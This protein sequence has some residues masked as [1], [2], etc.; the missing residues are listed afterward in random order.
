MCRARL[1]ETLY[2]AVVE[3]YANTNKESTPCSIDGVHDCCFGAAKLILCSTCCIDVGA[4]TVDKQLRFC[5]FFLLFTPDTRA[6]DRWFRSC[7][8]PSSLAF[9]LS[10]SFL[11]SLSLSLSR[12]LLRVLSPFPTHLF[13]LLSHTPASFALF[14]SHPLFCFFLGWVCLFEMNLKACWAW[15]NWQ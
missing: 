11:L 14:L 8:F 12:S 2:G 5:E 1:C 4:H 15:R 3:F 10:C 9:S 13:P 6:A 7:C